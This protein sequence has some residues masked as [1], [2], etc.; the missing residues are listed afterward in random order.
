MSTCDVFIWKP[1]AFDFDARSRLH[2]RE[3]KHGGGGVQKVF[4]VLGDF[5]L[6]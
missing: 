1:A 2:F 6:L 3:G 5:S 4:D